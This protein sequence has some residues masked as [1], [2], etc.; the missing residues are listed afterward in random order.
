[1]DVY[2]IWNLRITELPEKICVRM[3]GKRAAT[4]LQQASL[5]VA[6]RVN[7][8]QTGPREVIRML[9]FTA[10]CKIRVV[11]LCMRHSHAR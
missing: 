1:M 8:R 4:P 3:P 11:R 10:G 9:Q 5:V 7:Q 6:I 2:D